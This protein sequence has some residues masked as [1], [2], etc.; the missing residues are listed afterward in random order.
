M[1]GPSDET[2]KPEVHVSKQV[3]HDKDPFLFKN[4]LAPSVGLK[5]AV[6]LF[7]DNGEVFI[8]VKNSGVGRK[9][10]N[11]QSINPVM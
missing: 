1:G 2:A 7:T 6:L 5:F 4:P 9:T 11:N 3:W 8:Y 10:V